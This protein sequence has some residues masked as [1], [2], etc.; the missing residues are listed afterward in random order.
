MEHTSEHSGSRASKW[1]ASECHFDLAALGMQRMLP[2]KQGLS[3]QYRWLCQ[4]LSRFEVKADPLFQSAVCC[5]VRPGN[6][7][8]ETWSL[9]KQKTP[10]LRHSHYGSAHVHSKQ[11]PRPS[12]NEIGTHGRIKQTYILGWSS[13][14]CKK[15]TLFA[16]Q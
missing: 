1:Q 15:L 4:V 14:P 5:F 11:R 13:T 12:P 7:L 2:V 6:Q 9:T 10:N 8:L 16:G 3:K